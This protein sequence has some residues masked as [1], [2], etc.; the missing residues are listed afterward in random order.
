MKN[1]SIKLDLSKYKCSEIQEVTL[2]D[3][4][5][6]RAV[7]IPVEQNYIYIGK[8][9]WYSNL[10]AKEMTQPK[11]GITHNIRQYLTKEQFKKEQNLDRDNIRFLGTISEFNYSSNYQT[12]NSSENYRN[13]N[14]NQ[15]NNS[16][17]IDD[18]PF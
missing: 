4:T 13:D 5:K 16:S 7:I 3:G 1:L 18:L 14:F 9:G 17:D 6:C 8:K 10:I 15:N 2:Q 12:D 11:F